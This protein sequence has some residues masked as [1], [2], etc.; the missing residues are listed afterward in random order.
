MTAV[1]SSAVVSALISGVVSL[2]GKI[3]DNKFKSN[4]YLFT[5]L[6][7]VLIEIANHH[8]PGFDANAFEENSHK[9]ILEYIADNSTYFVYMHSRYNIVKP[10]L[11]KKTQSALD[12]LCEQEKN[13]SDRLMNEA[14]AKD[15][16]PQRTKI[17]QELSIA[18]DKTRE[19]FFLELI[20]A[21]HTQ[22]SK[23]MKP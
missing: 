21:I 5:E 23:K 13:E 8:S 11:P 16:T 15:N 1:I 6:H 20:Q 2:W 4:Y 17:I 9:Y 14:M 12:S 7:K 22:L 3:I 19:R 18:V 10:L